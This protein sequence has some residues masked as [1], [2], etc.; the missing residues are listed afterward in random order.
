MIVCWKE[1]YMF[2]AAVKHNEAGPLPLDKHDFSPNFGQYKW[3]CMYQ[4]LLLKP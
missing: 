3:H 2:Y 4:A 1:R